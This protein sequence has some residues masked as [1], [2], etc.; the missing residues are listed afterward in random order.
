M[1][2]NKITRLHRAFNVAT[3]FSIVVAGICF[4][5]GC[6]R[7]YYNYSPDPDSLFGFTFIGAKNYSR[8]MVA[9]TFRYIAIPVYA[10][11]A[12]V[13]GNLIFAFVSPLSENKKPQ[14]KIK[15]VVTDEKNRRFILIVNAAVIIVCA[16]V[17]LIYALNIANFKHDIMD[18][19]VMTKSVITAMWVMIPCLGISF[20]SALV[21]GILLGT[22]GKKQSEKG[23]L[24]SM[25]K[26][27]PWV[28]IVVVAAGIAL[29]VVGLVMGGTA[30]VLGKAINI[31][32]ECIGLG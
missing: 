16:T 8:E 15:P 10:C 19:S 2:K 12:L 29:L 24:D 17:F 21:S 1:T 27:I 28:R 20:A 3:A 6:L 18:P 4:I 9:E 7:I 14:K 31:C 23:P 25:E 11:L 26:S 22:N 13:I 30:D 32:T 5:L